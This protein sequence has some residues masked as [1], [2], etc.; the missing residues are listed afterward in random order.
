LYLVFGSG[1]NS[2]AATNNLIILWP[3]FEW[4]QGMCTDLWGYTG[5]DYAT[6]NAM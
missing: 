2:Y 3:Q 1:W 4:T 5:E 6:K